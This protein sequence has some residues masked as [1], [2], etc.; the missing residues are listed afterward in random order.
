MRISLGRA[1][2]PGQAGEHLEDGAVLSALGWAQGS[3][4][5]LTAL[6]IQPPPP[7]SANRYLSHS[8]PDSISPGA[9]DGKL[10]PGH[11]IAL[12]EGMWEDMYQKP[13]Y[14]TPLISGANSRVCTLITYW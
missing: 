13:C 9:T 1:P 2:C 6:V 14:K 8:S 10:G 4:R 11:V 3:P 12:W 7:R 5:P